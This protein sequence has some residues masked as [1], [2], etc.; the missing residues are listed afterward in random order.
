MSNF[1]TEVTFT[2]VL[3]T[4]LDVKTI[5]R[6]PLQLFTYFNIQSCEQLL[7]TFS[8]NSRCGAAPAGFNSIILYT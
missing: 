6:N 8:D 1:V 7:G 4:Y 3:R 2:D 5:L